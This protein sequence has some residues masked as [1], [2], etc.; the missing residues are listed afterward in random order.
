[1]ALVTTVSAADIQKSDEWKDKINDEL[2]EVMQEKSNDELIPIYLWL[3]SVDEDIITE[4][5]ISE[6]G[7]DP[8][9]YEDE[10]RFN[11]EI[12]SKITK[13]IENAVG[14]EEAHRVI[15]LD[16]EQL[17]AYKKTYTSEILSRTAMIEELKEEKLIEQTNSLVDRAINAK[18]DEYVMSHREITKREYSSVNDKFIEDNIN[19]NQRQIIYNSRYTST[20]ILEATKA[21]IENYAKMDKVSRISLYVEMI[22]EPELYISTSQTGVS[23]TKGRSY[24]SGSGYKG[25]GIKIGVLEAGN[26]IYDTNAPQLKGIN[27]VR[28]FLSNNAGVNGS[29]ITTTVTNHATFVTSIIVGQPIKVNGPTF[30]GVAPLATVYQTPAYGSGD[31]LRGFEK[32]VDRGVSIINF[33]GGLDTGTGY[34]N[35]DKAIDE[36][37]FNTKVTF[38]KS[39]GNTNVNV[40]SPGKAINGITVG[41]AETKSNAA[42]GFPSPYNSQSGSSYSEA[43]HLPN[44][45]D[46]TAPG[47]NISFVI[48][49]GTIYTDTGTS[50]SA[51]H[52]TGIIAQMMQVNST[53]K[54]NPAG[55]KSRLLLAADYSKITTTD[56]SHV[57][58]YLRDKSGA[59]FILAKKAIEAAQNPN[60]I[61]LSWGE[62]PYTS[63]NWRFNA[64]QKIRL[65]MTY[66]WKPTDLIPNNTRFLDYDIFIRDSSK[67][68]N[69]EGS[70]SSRNNVEIVEYTF[71]K[72]GF[73]Y[74][75]IKPVN[76]LSGK[77][78]VYI[79][80]ELT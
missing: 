75:Y 29:A 73:Y 60:S 8:A 74:F 21:E 77:S 42:A 32:L 15:D 26:D 53:L 54:T 9:V 63:Y 61:A 66:G 4:A 71:T 13:Q 56:N 50:F 17:G 69:V 45:P 48:S 80:W 72:T 14:Y 18:V 64:G 62:N 79:T 24:N 11:E 28:L 22:V 33:S 30:E 31:V 78:S 10:N 41:N 20:M 58:D 70:I 68:S 12:A 52:I 67:G 76:Y 16:L 27:N 40:S 25:A 19:K 65:V 3:Q 5:L 37:I 51:P 46:I 7:L 1:M 49:P 38:V 59:G 43:P 44:K 2:W 34:H 57:G 36:L 39:A 6:K 55:V 23:Y 35:F 47:T